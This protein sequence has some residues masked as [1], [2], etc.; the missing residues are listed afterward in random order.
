MCPQSAPTG[1]CGPTCRVRSPASTRSPG[2]ARRR[3]RGAPAPT[4]S[5][6]TAWSA[7]SRARVCTTTARSTWAE[8]GVWASVPSASVPRALT[9]GAPPPAPTSA[10]SHKLTAPR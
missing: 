4:T 1:A 9:D 7:S 6:G 5:F 8:A 10:T 2:V 3:A